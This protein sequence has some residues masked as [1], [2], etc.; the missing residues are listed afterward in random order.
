MV[1]GRPLFI[2]T[3]VR[4]L[5]RRGFY[6]VTN[7]LDDFL[8]VESSM[9]RCQY[10]QSVIIYFLHYLGFKVAWAKCSSPSTITRYLGILFDSNV[11]QLRL[12]EDKMKKMAVE[13]EF[14]SGRARARL[15]NFRNF[16]GS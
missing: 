9:E 14:F 13:L 2:F 15:D 8:C 16:V 7:Y 6:N 12:P 4:C 3:Q 5:E 10:V 11:M 1:L